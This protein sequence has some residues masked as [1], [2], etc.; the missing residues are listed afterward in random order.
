M[1]L[2]FQKDR[3]EEETEKKMFEEI[4]AIFFFQIWWEYKHT[5]PNVL[6]NMIEFLKNNDKE[7]I[8]KASREK[9]HILYKGTEKI[10]HRLIIRNY[11]LQKT[12]ECIL[13]CWKKKNVNPEF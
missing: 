5:N 11:A 4:M 12:V 2:E 6:Y 9:R 8:F 7:N 1:K 3:I 13:K 10:N